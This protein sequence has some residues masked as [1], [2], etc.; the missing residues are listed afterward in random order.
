[1]PFKI[2]DNLTI[3]SNFKKSDFMKTS[4]Y[5]NQNLSMFFW[6][7]KDFRIKSHDFYVGF[8]FKNE[9][10]SQL[11]LYCVDKSLQNEDERKIFNDEFVK[12][13]TNEFGL[14][15]GSIKSIENKRDNIALI[16]LNYN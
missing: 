10:I 5:N 13:I 12:E 7:R 8:L 16:I 11:Q 6:I 1:M 3:S 9:E 4:F 2:A 14:N 15:P